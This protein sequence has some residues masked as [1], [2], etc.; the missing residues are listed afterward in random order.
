MSAWWLAGIPAAVIGSVLLAVGVY[1]L[2][3]RAYDSAGH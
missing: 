2:G 1:R 3:L